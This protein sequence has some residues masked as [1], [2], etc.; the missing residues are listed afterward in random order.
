M[1]FITVLVHSYFTY[2][3]ETVMNNKLLITF[4]FGSN[5]EMIY[6]CNTFAKYVKFENYYNED[7]SQ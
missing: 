6:I 4:Y 7:I 3:K 1:C 5:F 2:K